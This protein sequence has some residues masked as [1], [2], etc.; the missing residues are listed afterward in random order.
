M[1]SYPIKPDIIIFLDRVFANKI[2]NKYYILQV[3]FEN[4]SVN[5]IHYNPFNL[6]RHKYNMIFNIIF[7]VYQKHKLVHYCIKHLYI[8][9]LRNKFVTGP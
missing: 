3:Q 8:A 7:C 5:I 6:L 2:Y 9:A 1:S 4:K